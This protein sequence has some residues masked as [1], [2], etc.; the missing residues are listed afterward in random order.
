MVLYV[1]LLAEFARLY[2]VSEFY[3]GDLFVCWFHFAFDECIF[4][5]LAWIFVLKL[6]YFPHNRIYILS[7]KWFEC[8]VVLM[9]FFEMFA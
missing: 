3:Y 7:Y 8:G 9:S 5:F 2:I 1:G 4:Q 6:V